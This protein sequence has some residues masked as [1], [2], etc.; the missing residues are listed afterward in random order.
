MNTL[1]RWIDGIRMPCTQCGEVQ[2]GILMIGNDPVSGNTEMIWVECHKCR[3]KM[4]TWE[5]QHVHE[6]SQRELFD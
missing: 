3:H 4:M 2:Q 1:A 6:Y 5:L